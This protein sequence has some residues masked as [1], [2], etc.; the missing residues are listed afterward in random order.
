MSQSPRPPGP[1]PPPPP[2][3][4]A[5][6]RGSVPPSPPPGP[7]A[8]PASHGPALLGTQPGFLAPQP[9]PTPRRER[10][11]IGELL[12]EANAITPEQ[13]AEALAAQHLDNERVG[14]TLV[15]LQHCTDWDVCVALGKQFDLPVREH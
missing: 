6:I 8:A 10:R 3:P 9:A 13:L 12:L 7:A 5:G 1:P 2:R 11:P 4:P 15:R 14:E